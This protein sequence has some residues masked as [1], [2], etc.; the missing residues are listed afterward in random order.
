LRWIFAALAVVIL[1]FSQSRAG[2]AE[3]VLVLF[4]FLLVPE[5]RIDSRRIDSTRI[6]IAV[7]CVVSVAMALMVGFFFLN[8][9]VDFGDIMNGRLGL[10]NDIWNRAGESW[11]FGYG[12]GALSAKARLDNGFVSWAGQAHNQFLDTLFTGGVFS[13][14]SLVVLVIV[15]AVRALRSGSHRRVALAAFAV[16]FIDLWV[17]SPLRPVLA[18]SVVM[19][20]IVLAILSVRADQQRLI[21]VSKSSRD[22]ALD[23]RPEPR[24]VRK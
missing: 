4:V 1:V 19:A 23:L 16:L 9:V 2:W 5:G 14:A 21:V 13:L 10:W 15:C 7:L 6:P 8:P 3:G 20:V 12:M 22:L 11:L 17:E 18:A 24:M